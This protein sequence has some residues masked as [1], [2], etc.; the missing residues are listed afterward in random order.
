M[1]CA[2]IWKAHRMAIAVVVET[3][4]KRVFASALDWPGWSRCGPDEARSLSALADYADRY[5]V[6]ARRAG[7]R[8]P[9]AGTA[10]SFDVVERLAGSATTDFGAPGAIASAE[11]DTPTR[12]EADRL[13]RLLEAAWAV[14]DDVVATSPAELRKGPRGG[15]RDRDA[16]AEHV[17]AAESAY[18]RKVGLRLASPGDRAAVLAAIRRPDSIPPPGPRTK[19]WP[20]R[21][22]VRRAAWHA[23]DHAWEIEDR[24][25]PS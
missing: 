17:L 2:A 9:A 11:W 19:P 18:L 6:A 22:V 16:I 3:G 21:Y 12:A 4:K 1:V 15:G 10:G 13:A 25:E 23:L 7:L 8:L 14:L 24:Q 5:R 20:V